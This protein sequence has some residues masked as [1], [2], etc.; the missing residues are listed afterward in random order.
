MVVRELRAGQIDDPGSLLFGKGESPVVTT[1]RV[2]IRVVAVAVDER[3]RV[4]WPLDA[5]R[6]AVRLDQRDGAGNKSVVHG[7][8]R[9]LT[10]ARLLRVRVRAS[11]PTRE[12]AQATFG[13]HETRHRRCRFFVI[14]L[15]LARQTDVL[16]YQSQGA[17]SFTHQRDPRP[18]ALLTGDGV[19]DGDILCLESCLG[20]GLER[21]ELDVGRLAPEE[22]AGHVCQCR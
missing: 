22:C 18:T 5:S 4:R 19:E 17:V 9:L 3:V 10:R 13:T 6:V 1:T 2:V 20:R 21:Q 8:E 16:F 11:A 12:P 14:R 7:R 15:R